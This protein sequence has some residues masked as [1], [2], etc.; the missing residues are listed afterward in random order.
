MDKLAFKTE[1]FVSSEQ[2][3]ILICFCLVITVVAVIIRLYKD[4]FQAVKGIGV[5][6]I[7]VNSRAVS[8]TSTFYTITIDANVFYIYESSHGVIQLKSKLDNSEND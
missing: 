6:K 1:P 3:L 7:R 5:D 8:K 2:W 4:K